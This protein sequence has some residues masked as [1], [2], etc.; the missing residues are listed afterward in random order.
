[1]DLND[2]QTGTGVNPENNQNENNMASLLEKEGLGIDF[3]TQ[4]EIRK[5]V[6]ASVTPGQILVSVGTK[7]EGIITGKEYELIPSDELANLKI[8]QE[9]PVYVVNPEDQN[10]NLILSYMRAREE[11]GWS[12]VEALLANK[13]ATHSTV[14]GYNKGGLIVP[15]GGL[16]GF[17]PA[18]QISLTRRAGVTGDTPEQRWS[19]MIGSEID[20]CV[21][22]VDRERRRLILSERQASTET[23]ESVKERVLEELKEG[24]TYT[25]RVTSLADFG[26]F[27]NV[28]GADG[29][30][31]MSE[32]SWDR[33]Q[34]PSE[35][36]KVGQE[37]KVKVINID[38]EKKRIGLSIRQLQSDPWDQ[39]AAQ[40]HEGQLVEG[41]ITRLTK[42]G[43]FARLTDDIEG[44]IHISEI[45]EKRIEHPREVIKEGETYT[46]RV[47]KVDPTV[48]RIGLSLRRVDSMA[49]AD[50]DWQ[51]LEDILAEDEDEEKKSDESNSEK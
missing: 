10:G 6:V 2:S 30:V 35:V 15:I 26:V 34:H 47:I 4:G 3:P 31:H 33:I 14:I 44:L 29:L 22:E 51:S 45:S 48:H 43:A 1:M 40:F 50:M 39:K 13:Q 16:R 24:E 28:N 7:S 32:I 42:F 38:R 12:I 49:Y 36:L 11:E 21:I 23:R 46:L 9:I 8:G 37:V 5:G 27:V 41:T 17:V 18:S 20:V 19:K 25:G